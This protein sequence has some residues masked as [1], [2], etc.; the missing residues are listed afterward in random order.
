MIYRQDWQNSR[1]D[2][3]MKLQEIVNKFASNRDFLLAVKAEVV[4]LGK[5]RPDF[6]YNPFKMIVSCSYK[7]SCYCVDEK[8][9]EELKGPDCK[10]C[11]FGEALQNM[12]WSDPTEMSSVNQIQYLFEKTCGI[13]PSETVAMDFDSVQSAQDNGKTWGE[14]I[15]LFENGA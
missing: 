13:H 5:E 11:I 2:N 9:D 8:L 10:G 12:G 15:S 14:A 7:G 4:K 6:Q 3:K 1:K